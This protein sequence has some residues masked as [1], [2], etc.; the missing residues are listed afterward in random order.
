MKELKIIQEKLS[1]PKNQMN[2]FGKY[3]YRSCEDILEA[4][5]P[6]LNETNTT[7]TISDEI[8]NIGER[9]YIK[10]TV[11]LNGSGE[12]VSCTA[13]AREPQ[14]KKGMDEAQITG[15]TSSYARK[16]A[17]NGLFC[18][19]DT[20]DPDATN[21]HGKDEKPP[22]SSQNASESTNSPKS[23]HCTA[24]Q[25]KMI[26]GMMQNLELADKEALKF[27]DWLKE[28]KAV[29]TYSQVVNGEE[30][31]GFTK[32][33]ASYVIDNMDDLF[34]KYIQATDDIPH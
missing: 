13:Y 3:K 20:K 8:V 22:Q 15:S 18:I 6:L 9:Y 34:E 24:S 26:S 11:S 21:K 31:L 10:A 14:T 4:V 23:T 30:L 12:S 19:D 16:Y 27:K 28:Q 33:G 25:K 29:G 17:L 7:L 2:D 5:K 32:T 1:V